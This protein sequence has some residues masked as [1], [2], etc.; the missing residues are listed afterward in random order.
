[1]VTAHRKKGFREEWLRE[2][3]GMCSAANGL[4][5]I[6]A[7]MVA[8]VA[9]DAFGEIGPFQ[10]AIALTALAGLLILA[11]EENYGESEGDKKEDVG[12]K[13]SIWLVV[14]NWRIGLVAAS[15]SLFEGTMY[16]FVFMW[17][18]T[19][20]SLSSDPLPT[21]LVF[22]CLMACITI[23]GLLFEMSSSVPVEQLAIRVFALG[24]IAI[25]VP[26]FTDMFMV[27]FAA[28]CVFE[29]AVGMFFPCGGTLRSMYIPDDMQGVAMNVCR[30]PLNMLV[31]I[32]T[33]LSDLVR[34]GTVFGVCCSWLLTGLLCQ[35]VLAQS[36]DRPHT[37]KA[38]SA[39]PEKANGANGHANGANGAN[40]KP[41][42]KAIKK[43]D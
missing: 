7:G 21:G 11:W 35:F 5:A 1:M 24:A 9:C 28:F 37:P 4:M 16:T 27:V 3:F 42:K 18:P 12:I 39:W 38:G 32:G 40:G 26:V 2:T 34:P 22:S 15:T 23:G 8:Q 29:V 33:G 6:I 43:H 31:V 41:A 25:I 17:V 19:L 14:T 20:L 13:Q 10:A 30:L 36:K